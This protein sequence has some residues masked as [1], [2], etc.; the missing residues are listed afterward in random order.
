MITQ[1]IQVNSARIKG[2]Y[3]E[4]INLTNNGWYVM[5]NHI[6]GY[7]EPPEIEGYIPDIYAL[8]NNTTYI[9]V[10]ACHGASQSEKIIAFRKYS[11]E[12]PNVI[13]NSFFVNEA[14]CRVQVK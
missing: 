5:A 12:Y 8:K 1:N 7:N 6:P 9:M 4:A 10:I 14:G 13:F 11:G 3:R 2:I